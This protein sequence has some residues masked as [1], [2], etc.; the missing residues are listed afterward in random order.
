MRFAILGDH[1]DGR[2]AA[3]ALAASGRHELTAYTTANDA[4]LRRWAPGA[5]RVPDAEEILAD[6]AVDFVI[7]AGGPADLSVQLRRA[8]QSERHVLCVYPP[9]ET[10]D[11][12]YEADMMRKDVGRVLLPLLPGALHPAVR[13]LAEFVGRPG[14]DG[15]AVSPVGAFRLVEVEQEAP[16]GAGAKP[17]FPGW[18]LLR[19]LGGE[20]AEASALSGGEHVEAGAPV[21]ASGRFEAGGLFHVAFLAR[22]DGGTRFSVV[23]EQGRADLAFPVGWRGPAFLDWTDTSGELREEAWETW[24]PWPALAERLESAVAGAAVRP[25]WLDAVRGLELDDAVRRSVER[26]RSSVLEHQE[27]SEE[28]GFKGTMTLVGCGLIWGMLMLLVL[29]YWLP[30]IRW[31]MV[32]L[33]ALFLVLQ[34]LRYVIPSRR[35]K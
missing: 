1:P 30:S 11:I 27:S 31:L 23:G 22:P 13:R 33:L 16:S 26:R 9:G 6:P 21:L 20:I 14:K 28:T 24:D 34:L 5:R 2:A 25:S 17:T 19:A 29:S 10:P 8:L 7:T 12:A 18:E 3:A 4:D 15:P 35:G 32:G